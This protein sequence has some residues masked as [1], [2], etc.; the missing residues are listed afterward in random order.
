[1]HFWRSAVGRRVTVA[2]VD[3]LRAF[4]SMLSADAKV[5][6]SA[7]LRR[8]FDTQAGQW[9]HAPDPFSKLLAG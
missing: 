4:D 1:M 7:Q 6:V 5:F 3:S 9:Q 8:L 2:L